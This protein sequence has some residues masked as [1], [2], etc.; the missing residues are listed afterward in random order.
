[1][2]ALAAEG[3]HLCW[4]LLFWTDVGLR[5][6]RP[7][8]SLQATHNLLYL[9][10]RL[11]QQFPPQLRC[12]RQAEEMEPELLLNYHFWMCCQPVPLAVTVFDGSSNSMAGTGG[13]Q[14]RALDEEAWQVAEKDGKPRRRI[15]CMGSN[16][17]DSIIRSG[18]LKEKTM[19]CLQNSLAENTAWL[20]A[21][22][23]SPHTPVP[24]ST[25]QFVAALS[26]C[27]LFS[28]MRHGNWSNF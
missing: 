3:L 11:L 28:L 14:L 20:S 13:R 5:E 19:A 2:I 6:T 4:W 27:N 9:K 17:I 15:T 7:G 10:M 26:W 12:S 23:S 24:T 25:I 1:M 21:S 16:V 22:L 8:G 18:F